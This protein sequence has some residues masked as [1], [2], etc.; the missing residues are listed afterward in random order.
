M[1]ITN[2]AP[3]ECSTVFPTVLYS[4]LDTDLSAGA[5]V[6]V[7]LNIYTA[8]MIGLSPQYLSLFTS[9]ANFESIAV[10]LEIIL[11]WN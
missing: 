7:F 1:A 11:S 4:C 9:H 6:L 8:V 3:N 2:M 10:I 5:L